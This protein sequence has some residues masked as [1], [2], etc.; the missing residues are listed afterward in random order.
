MKI[1]GGD[2]YQEN[3]I[4]DILGCYH[5]YFVAIEVKQP[6]EEATPLQKLFLREV[7]DVGGFTC[8]AESVEDVVQ[9]LGKID[10][11]IAKGR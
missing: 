2:P 8:V 5:G 4:S 11:R 10:R 1:H 9:L 7:G 6:G 3:G